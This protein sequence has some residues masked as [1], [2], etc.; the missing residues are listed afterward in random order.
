MCILIFPKYS[1]I[2]LHTI[3]QRKFVR[4]SLLFNSVRLYMSVIC[5][6][7]SII[8]HQNVLY[9]ESLFFQT[10]IYYHMYPSISRSHIRLHAV[11]RRLA[12]CKSRCVDW[13][14]FNALMCME[15]SSVFEEKNMKIFLGHSVSMYLTYPSCQLPGHLFMSKVSGQQIGGHYNDD[16]FEQWRK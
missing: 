2:A 10:L 3:P 6:L 12:Y 7:L 14:I 15:K 1:V 5:P 11:F 13:I 16:L 9:D 4:F 8:Q